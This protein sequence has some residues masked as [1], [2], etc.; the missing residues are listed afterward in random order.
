MYLKIK[1]SPKNRFETLVFYQ[2]RQYIKLVP[3]IR[4]RKEE[5]L[6]LISG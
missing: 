5:E 2:K 1:K 3:L 4:I 6:N